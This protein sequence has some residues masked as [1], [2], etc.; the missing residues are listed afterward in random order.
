MSPLHQDNV[1]TTS[2][3][4]ASRAVDN[5]RQTKRTTLHGQIDTKKHDRLARQQGK[6]IQYHKKL[7]KHLAPL[8]ELGLHNWSK[9]LTIQR[10]PNGNYTQ[11]I[12]PTN[13]IM[14]RL[15]NEDKPGPETSLRTSLDTLRASLLLP[16][17]T[18]L[19]KLPTD[20]T[21][22]LTPKP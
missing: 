18:E 8:W 9:H 2:I 14:A 7:L 1:V 10:H 5:T 12:Q 17:T 3:R 22:L 11:H 20:N 21:P 19:R 15:P 13:V 6:P 4:E 16:A